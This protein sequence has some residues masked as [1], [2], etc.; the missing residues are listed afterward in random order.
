MRIAGVGASCLSQALVRLVNYLQITDYEY[1]RRTFTLPDVDA[2][3]FSLL[4]QSKHSMD[5][6]DCICSFIYER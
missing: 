1:S 6:V 5:I 2:L 4:L 3:A